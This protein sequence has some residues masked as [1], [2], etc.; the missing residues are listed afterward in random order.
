MTNKST[1]LDVA[2]HSVQHTASVS[3]NELTP[4]VYTVATHV[5]LA[6]ALVLGA[7]CNRTWNLTALQIFQVMDTYSLSYS[8]L[9][10]L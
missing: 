9:L 4:A 8:Y 6:L 10:F 3:F 2:E 5:F 7:A 1:L